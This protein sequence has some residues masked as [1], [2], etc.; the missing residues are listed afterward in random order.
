MGGEERQKAVVKD[1]GRRII[2]VEG[3]WKLLCEMK[4]MNN[5]G[6]MTRSRRQSDESFGFFI[7]LFFFAFGWSFIFFVFSFFLGSFFTFYTLRQA[8]YFN[9][10]CNPNNY[11]TQ[12]RILG[13]YV[14]KIL[15]LRR[16][17]RQGL[18]SY[19]GRL[20]G[21][22][23]R[24][25]CGYCVMLQQY[26]GAEYFWI[27]TLTNQLTCTSHVNFMNNNDTNTRSR[28]LSLPIRESHAQTRPALPQ[29]LSTW[30]VPRLIK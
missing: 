26:L 7:N 21:I 22:I 14:V 28:T 1:G 8:P 9:S 23:L 17:E 4:R 5:M 3:E 24:G 29:Y 18:A 19:E 2:R 27:L 10:R 13:R 6:M 20:R 25:T 15:L 11:N 16:V 12:Q 30:W